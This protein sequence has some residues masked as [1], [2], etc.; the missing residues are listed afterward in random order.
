MGWIGLG[1]S[2]LVLFVFLR[3]PSPA[4]RV[5][6]VDCVGLHC[7][8]PAKSIRLHAKVGA[9]QASPGRFSACI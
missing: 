9:D 5:I 3:W 8:G 7:I 4:Q 6:G 2:G 1:G